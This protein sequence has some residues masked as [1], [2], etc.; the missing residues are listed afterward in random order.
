VVALTLSRGLRGSHGGLLIVAVVLIIV[1]ATPAV[2]KVS[3][4]ERFDG[5]LVVSGAS[6]KRKVVGSVVAAQGVFTAPLHV[7]WVR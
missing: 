2:A 5:G 3:G 6:G 7:P 1:L 4:T